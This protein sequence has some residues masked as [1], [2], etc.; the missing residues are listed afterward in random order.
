MIKSIS[1]PPHL[2]E[3]ASSIGNFSGWVQEQLEKEGFEVNV[4]MHNPI[5]E[6][7]VCN[8]MRKPTCGQ[9]YPEGP[10][11]QAEWLS[12]RDS[13]YFHDELR[14]IRNLTAITSEIESA[15]S[16]M[17]GKIT[18]RLEGIVDLKEKEDKKST[19]RRSLLKRLKSAVSAFKKS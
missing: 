13:L 6:L 4:N 17:L 8:G 3:K 2:A 9:C 10:P 7:G 15:Y 5:P 14:G 11:T 1:L 16:E 19:T 18:H 12:F